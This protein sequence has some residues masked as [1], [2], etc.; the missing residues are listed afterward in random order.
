VL[1]YELDLLTNVKV[2][3]DAIRFLEYKSRD[4]INKNDNETEKKTTKS[5]LLSIPR[6]AHA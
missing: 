1:F 6:V 3:D 2:V 4:I 5:V